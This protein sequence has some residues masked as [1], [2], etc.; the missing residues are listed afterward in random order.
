[1]SRNLITRTISGTKVVAKVVNPE[2]DAITQKEIV[3]DKVITD[4]NKVS[5][6]VAKALD[7]NTEVLVSVVSTEQIDK[8]FGIT[9]ADFM[10]NAVE[11]DPKTRAK[12]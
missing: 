3:L 9:V 8:L 12:L 1:M 5:K 7:P 11:L 4:A 10:A 2:T 6:A